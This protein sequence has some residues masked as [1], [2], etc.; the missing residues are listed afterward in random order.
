MYFAERAEQVSWRLQTWG[1]HVVGANSQGGF[2]VSGGHASVEK[3]PPPGSV[4]WDVEKGPGGP[5]DVIVMTQAPGDPN[6]PNVTDP[7]GC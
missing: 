2:M 6:A 7:T 4:V 1:S 3:S 5:A